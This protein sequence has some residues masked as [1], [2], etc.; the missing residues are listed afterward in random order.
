[1]EQWSADIGTLA[2]AWHEKSCAEVAGAAN[3]SSM[4]Y[5]GLCQKRNCR[6]TWNMFRS[7][8]NVA[9]LNVCIYV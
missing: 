3:K 7:V 2:A 4:S 1:M 9:L 5:G 6:R 8:L